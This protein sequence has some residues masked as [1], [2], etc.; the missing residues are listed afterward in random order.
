MDWSPYAVGGAAARADSFTGLDPDFAANA[1]ALTKA[2][3]DAGFPLQ[4]TS[5]YR[6]PEVQARLFKNAVAKY[7]S[8][9]A[10]RKWV[11]P[12]G[13]SMH[14]RG[15]AIDF[16]IDGGLLR[17]ANHPAAKWIA[18]NAANY[19]LA[20]PM[21][22]EPWQI[23]PAGGRGQAP[24]APAASPKSAPEAQGQ[25]QPAPDPRN[26]LAALTAPQNGPTGEQMN[27]LLALLQE[28]ERKNAL[29]DTRIDPFAF[30][31]NPQPVQY[32]AFDTRN[33]F[34]GLL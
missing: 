13:R 32:A 31:S 19:G 22:W 10:A 14:N 16:A 26:A 18:E 3:H 23:E 27:A 28:Q 9:A 12:P 5:A 7:G 20:V 24:S 6:S 29:V 11:A 33:P 8:E 15:M 25:P 1:Y 17:D 2:A 30:M 21:S 4:I 34:G